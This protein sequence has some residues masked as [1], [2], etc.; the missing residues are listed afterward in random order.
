MDDT[1]IFIKG[2]SYDGTAPDA[3]FW[4]GGENRS[5]TPN[6]KGEI[7]PYPEDY[8]GKLVHCIIQFFIS[9][10]GC[11][12]YW[13]F[14]SRQYMEVIRRMFDDNSWGVTYLRQAEKLTI[15]VNFFNR[16]W[17]GWA[18]NVPYF[19]SRLNIFLTNYLTN[20]GRFYFYCVPETRKRIIKI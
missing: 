18:P 13:G 20:T 1:T 19:F 16:L 3:F 4:V 11:W 10:N 7:V 12:K 14:F 2:F 15:F 17:H 5:S 6:P 9:L 8:K